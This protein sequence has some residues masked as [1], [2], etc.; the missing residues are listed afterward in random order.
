LFITF[1]YQIRLPI[2]EVQKLEFKPTDTLKQVHDYIAKNFTKDDSFILITPFPRKEFK[3]NLL[4]MTL[5]E[6]GTPFPALFILR[7][8]NL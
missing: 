6:A 4:A 2:G 3:D 5:T 1:E 7:F 8:I